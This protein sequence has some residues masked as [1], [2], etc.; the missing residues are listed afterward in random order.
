MAGRRALLVAAALALLS[1]CG[2][3]ALNWED[4]ARPGVHVVRSG[5]TL[6]SIAW[7][8]GLEVRD[9][10]AWNGLGDGR[11]IY[12][13]QE[14]RLRPKEGGAAPGG[15]QASA[16]NGTVSRPVSRPEVPPP[17]WRWPTAG[18]VAAAFAADD[19]ARTG[20]L[21]AGRRGQEIVAA[22]EGRVV[23]AG[24]GLIGYGKLVIIKHNE[25]Y[26]SAYG[27]NDELEVEEGQQVRQGQR[28]A[29]MGQG[30]GQQ[31][32]LHFEI[33]RNGDPVDPQLLLPR[34]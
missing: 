31:P 7:R 21:I 11:L 30:P 27:H 24:S 22:A 5:E 4:P 34:R 28:I 2:G 32:R 18:P 23:Y 10:A 17:A 20:I 15:R 26:L 33:R 14:I 16:S 13:G 3:R 19:R 6:Y 12:P 1:A 8:Y 25:S 9:L 29:L